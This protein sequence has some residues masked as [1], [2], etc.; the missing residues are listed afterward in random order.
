MPIIAKES[1]EIPVREYS[2]TIEKVEITSSQNDDGKVVQYVNCHVNTG[3][4]DIKGWNGMFRF[5]VPAN[6]TKQ[7]GL[8]KLLNRLGLSFTVGQSFDEQSLKGLRVVFDTRREGYFTNVIV[9]S[10]HLADE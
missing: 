3:T 2:G 6:L 10:V 1:V 4:T 5:S 7:T 9:D 8:G